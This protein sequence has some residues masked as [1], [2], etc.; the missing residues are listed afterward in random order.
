MTPA[1]GSNE[2][3]TSE[4]EDMAQFD[5]IQ[6]CFKNRLILAYVPASAR[7]CGSYANSSFP[8]HSSE[9]QGLLVQRGPHCC[10]GEEECCLRV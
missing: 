5:L 1:P 4:A 7:S 2:Q 3:G 6:V 9:D 10:G 8:T